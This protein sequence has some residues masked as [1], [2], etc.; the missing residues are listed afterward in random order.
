MKNSE[1]MVNSLLQ[2]RAQYAARQKRKRTVIACTAASLCCVCLIA[3]LGF[4]I[5]NREPAMP[6]Q[7]LEGPEHP[8]INETGENTAYDPAP[9]NKIVIHTIDSIPSSQMGI[10]LKLDDFVEMTREEMIEYIGLDYIPDVPADLSL[11]ENQHCGIYRRNGGTGEVYYDG[12]VLLYYN[13]NLT[14]CVALQVD[15]GTYLY[16]DH[17]FLDGTEEKSVINNVE[18]FIGLTADGHYYTE[19]MYQN[20]GFLISAYGVTQEEFISVISS[21]TQ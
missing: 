20:V 16:V 14:R 18:V 19:F 12:D 10:A 4:G 8:G 11:R 17:Y 7:T 21:V 2:R 3:L 9:K 13:A 5:G 6:D 1:E 15:K